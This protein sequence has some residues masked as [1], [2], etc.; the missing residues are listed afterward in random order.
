MI[1]MQS[2]STSDGTYT[3]VVTFAVGTDLNFA[4][5]LVQNRVQAALSSLPD[6]VQKQGVTVQKQSTAILMFVTL[7]SPDNTFDSLLSRKLRHDP[8]E[9]RAGAAARRRQRAGVRRRPVFDAH[10]AR[11]GQAA[12]ARP[13]RAGRDAGAAAAEPAG[14]RR[15]DRRAAGAGRYAVPVHGDGRRPACRRRAVRERDRQDRQRRRDHARCATSAASS[16]ARRPTGRSSRSTTGRPPAS[17]C[18]RRRAP[19]P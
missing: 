1:Y 8:P 12:G 3:L 6:A 11:S 19:T 5:I 2:M 14:R 4:Q 16:S 18:S 7:S 9:G 13:D 17:P 15:P 10:L